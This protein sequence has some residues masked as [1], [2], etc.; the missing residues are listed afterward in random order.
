ML[1]EKSVIFNTAQLTQ[2]QPL[3]GDQ[4]FWACGQGH[5]VPVTKPS[6]SPCLSVQS[7][8][9]LSVPREVQC[10]NEPRKEFPLAPAKPEQDLKSSILKKHK[11]FIIP[12]SGSHAAMICGT[13]EQYKP[14]PEPRRAQPGEDVVSQLSGGAPGAARAKFV[15]SVAIL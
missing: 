7:S 9:H 10:L 5:F 3:L 14:A 13:Q 12:G 11:Y 1:E 6:S 8:A 4:R 15:I 2:E